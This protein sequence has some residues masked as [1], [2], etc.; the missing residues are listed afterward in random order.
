MLLLHLEDQD[1]L[2]VFTWQCIDKRI[3][4]MYMMY[5]CCHHSER[6][7]ERQ[8]FEDKKFDIIKYDFQR[9]T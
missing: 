4:M 3:I 7:L 2:W 9:Y 5:F 8:N 1:P 6:T